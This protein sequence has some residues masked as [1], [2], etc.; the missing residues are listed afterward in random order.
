MLDKHHRIKDYL[1]KGKLAGQII[2]WE[3]A[4]LIHHLAVYFQD[5]YGFPVLTV[6]D[7][8]IV[9]EEEQP[10]I[11]EFMFTTSTECEICDH[12]SLM[13]QIKNL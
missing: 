13:D 3:E 12:Y 4:N 1:L 11:K 8:F 10:M 6:Y 2:Q 9:P 5:C 7:E